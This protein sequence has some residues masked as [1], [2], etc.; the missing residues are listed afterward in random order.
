MAD[1]EP[2]VIPIVPD[3]TAILEG[4][5][6]V[7]VAAD[8]AFGRGMSRA[9]DKANQKVQDLTAAQERLNAVIE[10]NTSVIGEL[11]SRRSSADAA[12]QA[13]I[14]QQITSLQRLNQQHA[15]ETQTLEAKKVQVGANALAMLAS[16]EAERTVIREGV[17]A[18]LISIQTLRDQD[19]AYN[20]VKETGVAAQRA[21]QVQLDQVIAKQGEVQSS[22]VQQTEAYEA[23]NA[24]KATA[25]GSDQPRID[26]EMA[27]IRR[28]LYARE[29]ENVV[30]D[31]KRVRLEADAQIALATSDAERD[32]IRQTTDA[33][34]Q[35]LT[36]ELDQQ[37][38]RQGVRDTW[39]A[40]TD[41]QRAA[42]ATVTADEQRLTETIQQQQAV[43][44]QMRTD[45]PNQPA[46]QQG[47]T[48]SELAARQRIID[49]HIQEL[50]IVQQKRVALEAEA[51]TAAA[52]SDAERASIAQAAEAERRVIQMQADE[53]RAVARTRDVRSQAMAQATQQA[54]ELASREA[55]NN[56]VIEASIAREKELQVARQSASSD[57][58]S[59]IDNEIEQLQR[60]VVARENDNLKLAEKKVL[61]GEATALSEATSAEERSTIQQVTAA[62]L[63]ELSIQRDQAAAQRTVNEEVGGGIPIVGQFVSMFSGLGGALFA[64]QA[65]KTVLADDLQIM[66]QIVASGK[67]LR[68]QAGQQ[69]DIDKGFNAELGLDTAAD[70]A[71]GTAAITAIQQ[72][73]KTPRQTIAETGA[74][75]AATLKRSGVDDVSSPQFQQLV[76]SASLYAN[77]G[78]EPQNMAYFVQQRLRDNPQLTGDQLNQ[79]LSDLRQDANNDPKLMNEGL[80]ILSQDAERFR[81]AGLTDRDQ[82]QLFRRGRTG[83]SCTGGSRHHAAIWPGPR[84]A[85]GPAAP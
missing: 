78:V 19:R 17:Q 43:V 1:I 30:L 36:V 31:A 68:D 64:L 74:A 54:A 45:R 42:L 26:A 9:I 20:A 76:G 34:L 22:I 28:V 29:N 24:S 52:T 39:S 2:I 53:Q 21:I 14:D 33:R 84:P 15:I 83:R 60:S 5:A 66:Q 48:D 57:E 13:R 44:S 16:N 35:E 58:R 81:A 18:Q 11:D 27:A 8:E 69:Y 77:K 59:A 23:L 25:P 82:L 73:Y 61:L 70:E 40:A 50:A 79:E 38:V 7:Q 72:Q 85:A 6:E 55:R 41:R 62:R 65:I 3:T 4:L 56:A 75:L 67:T 12:E 49:Q 10:Q 46:G 47:N 37:R 63:S 71:K 32:G 80:S 51:A